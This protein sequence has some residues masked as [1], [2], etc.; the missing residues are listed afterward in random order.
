MNQVRPQAP[1]TTNEAIDKS[2]WH[3]TLRLHEQGKAAERERDAAQQERDATQQ[4]LDTVTL[5]LDIARQR[6]RVLLVRVLVSQGTSAD[7]L[8]DRSLEELRRM[9]AATE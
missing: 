4:Q 2:F 9:V 1:G 6:E 5:E 8:Q 3:M 7:E